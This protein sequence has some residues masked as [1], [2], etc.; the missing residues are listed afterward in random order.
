MKLFGLQF[1]AASSLLLAAL[2]AH[3]ETRPQYGGTLHVSLREA[4]VSLNPSDS[5][6]PD[7][8]GRRN[9]TLLI[10]E[11][12]V[13]TDES[14][15]IRPGLATSWISD[16]IGRNQSWKFPIRAGVKFHDG[17]KLTPEIAAASLRLANPSWKIASDADSI[18]IASD[19]LTPHLIDELALPRNAIAKKT[20]D[21]KFLGTGP[22]QIT[23]WQPGKKLTLAANE[24]YWAGRPFL[25]AM[26]IE[27][28]K[29]FHEQ[30]IAQELGKADMIEIL[31]EQ[32]RRVSTASHRLSGSEP[33]ELI[34]LVFARDAQTQ[35]EKSLREALALCIERASIGSVIL[36]GAGRP[37]ASI[38]PDWM[39]GYAFS[40]TSEPDLVRARHLREEVRAVPHW[41]V[42]Y[43]TDDPV[44]GLLAE[45][46]ALNARDVG[47]QLQ[48]AKT[49]T[50]D[51]RVVRISLPSGPL[52]ALIQ[53]AAFVGLPVPEI[54]GYSAEDLYT[55]ERGMLA[56]QKL[57]PLFHLPVVYAATPDLKDWV[58]QP[59]STWNLADS[60]L[61]REPAGSGNP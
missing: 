16:A 61:A 34:A 42:S 6:Q 28:G 33:I 59:N 46:I 38:L 40:F 18:T 39:S 49:A 20:D 24:N 13:T 17:T 58:P 27:F 43:D 45:R 1:L 12:L 11:T 51:L 30:L 41:T 5:T 29:N 25:D 2:A 22:F 54:D 26:E 50:A 48:P 7:S 36:Q 37:S 52:V 19:A 56:A 60:W 14:G 3:A 44:A 9:L 21:G 4:P 31:A 35:D 23:D 10:F 55:A 53:I 47:L 57:I 15:G 8:F 32:A